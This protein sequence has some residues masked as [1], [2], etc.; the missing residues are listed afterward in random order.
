MEAAV[1]A[2]L[3]RLTGANDAAG[4]TQMA[5]THQSTLPLHLR[6]VVA[7]LLPADCAVCDQSSAV[8]RPEAIFA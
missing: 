2:E 3:Q 8:E 1:A 4:A 7:C 5:A 6:G